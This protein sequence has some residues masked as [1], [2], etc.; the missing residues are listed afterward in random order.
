[1]RRKV[2]NALIFKNADEYALRRVRK[3]QNTA[4]FN[5]ERDEENDARQAFVPANLVPLVARYGFTGFLTKQAFFRQKLEQD[6]AFIHA[7]RKGYRGV[8][9]Q[10]VFCGG[11]DPADLVHF[12]VQ[13]SVSPLFAASLNCSLRF[14]YSSIG[15]SP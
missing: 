9:L 15:K 14:L 3:A 8:C 1:M 4:I 6:A 12:S 13:R 11:C 7:G 2:G 5:R 10:C